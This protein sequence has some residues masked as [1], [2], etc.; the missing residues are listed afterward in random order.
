MY[1]NLEGT[2][3]NYIDKYTGPVSGSEFG[4]QFLYQKIDSKIMTIFVLYQADNRQVITI[5][6]NSDERKVKVIQ[7]INNKTQ[8]INFSAVENRNENT[9]VGMLRTSGDSS[10]ITGDYTEPSNN[11]SL[12]IFE[13]NQT[14]NTID[15]TTYENNYGNSYPSTTEIINYDQK[16]FN[17]SQVDE[18]DLNV[19]DLSRPSGKSLMELLNN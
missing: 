11:F 8:L 13:S 18:V 7:L 16:S 9:F 4:L 1:K 15:Q 17:Y 5:E 6:Q 2:K 10:L 19:D 3:I 14:F 12:G